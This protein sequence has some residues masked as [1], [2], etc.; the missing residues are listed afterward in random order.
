V[1]ALV[2]EIVAGEHEVSVDSVVEA[3]FFS[4]RTVARDSLTLLESLLRVGEVLPLTSEPAR[5]AASCLAP[6]DERQRRAHFADALIAAIAH[7]AGATLVTG[8]HR[9]AALFPIAVL[10]Y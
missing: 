9:I 2:G 10:A 8:D 7:T 5:L 6:M 3:E 4:A 1:R